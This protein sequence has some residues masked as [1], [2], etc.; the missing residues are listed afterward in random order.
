[1]KLIFSIFLII[2]IFF[3]NIFAN[4]EVKVGIYQKLYVPSEKDYTEEKLKNIIKELAEFVYK[5]HVV[6]NEDKKTFGMTYEF[7]ENGKWIQ[8]FGLDTMHDGS[9]FMSSI[10]TAYRV[11]KDDY[12]LKNVLKYQVPFY[13]NTLKNS[14]KLFPE[15]KETNE[16]KKPLKP[17]VKGYLPR[18]WDD[19]SGY[20]LYKRNEKFEEG[21]FTSSNHLMQDIADGLLNVY[22]TI[23]NIE[24]A[25][26]IK[27]LWE[28][29]TNFF[30]PIR[31]IDIAYGFTNNRLDL[32]K[33]Y[34]L[35]QF[36]PSSIYPYYQGMYEFKKVSL[37]TYNDGLAWNYTEG[38]V[39]YLINGEFN[40][41]FAL[42]VAGYCY[43]TLV[44]YEMYHD[45]IPYQLGMYFFD[46]Q[47]PPSFIDGKLDGYVSNSKKLFGARGIQFSWLSAAILPVLSKNPSLWEKYFYDNFKED[48]IVR[49]I[50][51]SPKIDGIKE[52]VYETKI[53]FEGGELFLVSD[54]K[55]I[56]IFISS[57]LPEINF[58]ISSLINEGTYGH[59]LV[60]NDGTV[61]IIN[62]NS[63][64]LINENV[65]LKNETK[66]TVEIRIPYTI[67]P[68]Q[69]KWINGVDYGRYKVKI[70]DKEKIIC[71]LSKGERI[72]KKL[73]N[74]VLGTIDTWY[75]IWKEIGFIPSGY[76][77]PNL[78]VPSWEISDVGNY[79]HL[80]KTISLWVV[81]KNNTSEWEL[82]K[83]NLPT[84]QILFQPIPDTV[85]KLQGLK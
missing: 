59:I 3:S 31:I 26:S 75:K 70:K 33:K 49:M 24:V 54:P 67:V 76:K 52:S 69:K 63:E 60:K 1:M 47:G 19:G 58:Y 2:L 20:K 43:G 30:G 4:E 38:L 71:I 27:Y 25:E 62:Q 23:K 16:D 48:T 83:M 18:G 17:P 77:S 6:K 65:F 9:W 35:P 11:T 21:Y 50:D 28:Y 61:K 82:I 72:V 10:I 39:N 44:S 29:K 45:K 80:I 34:K 55:N 22:L 42:H 51:E 74:M 56:F 8:E 79:A 32:I 46:I 40:E 14:D 15:M 37:P 84:D 13:V 68:E 66:W 12:Y 85:L 81:Y 36:S 73:E 57:N 78:R 5:N 41:N 7:Y 53:D 64:R